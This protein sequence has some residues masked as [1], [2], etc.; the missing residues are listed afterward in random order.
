M[1]RIIN[2]SF[3]L[4][5]TLS[6]VSCLKDRDYVDGKIGHKVA[7]QNIIELAWP[8]SAS[9]QTTIAMDIAN[10]DTSIRLIPVRLASAQVAANDIV[11]T[12]DTS[13]TTKYVVDNIED[14][15]AL[16]P[17]SSAI[18]S[19]ES[20]LTVTIP[21]GSNEGY[22]TVKVNS[23]KFDPAHQYA[24]A[25]KIANVSDPNYLASGLLNTH[26][27]VFSA[28]NRYDGVYKLTGFHNR[29]PYN[30]PYVDVEMH[31]VTLTGNSVGV[32]WPEAGSW[33]H[34]IGVGPGQVSWYGAAIAPVFVFDLSTNNVTSAFNQGGATVISLYT[35]TQGSD[36]MPNKY[37]PA[38]KTLKVSWMYSN[39]PLR[40][41]FDTFVYVKPRP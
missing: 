12:L 27:F 4:L 21:K 29:V 18:G 6:F 9:G 15:E 41:F 39:N 36:A 7:D 25:Y 23:S 1:K 26:V 19:L 2:L 30:F 13:Q 40:A 20:G 34:P 22:I 14:N 16:L 8:G 31:L 38:T 28:K 11:I 10:K 32:Y 35:T 17:F 33:G 37:D 24:L 5:I 3:L